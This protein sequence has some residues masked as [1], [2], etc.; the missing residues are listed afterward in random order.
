MLESMEYKI[1]MNDLPWDE[2][3]WEKFCKFAR[4][5]HRWLEFTEEKTVNICNKTN[6]TEYEANIIVRGLLD[7]FLDKNFPLKRYIPPQISTKKLPITT[8]VISDTYLF[9]SLKLAMLQSNEK[10]CET[11][12]QY[13]LDIKMNY[14]PSFWHFYDFDEAL[15]NMVDIRGISYCDIMPG[16]ICDDPFR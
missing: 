9:L 8:N 1:S 13:F 4:K 15:M 16:E 3:T 7:E 14:A 2:K 5:K 6:F 10:A 12:D 11:L